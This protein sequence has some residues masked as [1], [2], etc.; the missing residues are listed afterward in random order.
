MNW[1]E[2]VIYIPAVQIVVSLALTMVGLLT[3]MSLLIL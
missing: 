2:W 1:V 3:E